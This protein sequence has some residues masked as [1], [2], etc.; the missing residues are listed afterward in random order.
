[1]TVQSS[2]WGNITTAS[3]L[4]R[5]KGNQQSLCDK[6]GLGNDILLWKIIQRR[7]KFTIILSVVDDL[8]VCV[9]CYKVSYVSIS[10]FCLD[11]NQSTNHC[12]GGKLKFGVA[13]LVRH[14]VGQIITKK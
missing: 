3:I 5:A 13:G 1:M 7:P 11:C 8:T 4:T 10:F 12:V 6:L 2:D 14:N 9:F